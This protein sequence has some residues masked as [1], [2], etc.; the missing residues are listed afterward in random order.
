MKNGGGRRKHVRSREVRVTWGRQNASCV[1]R[2]GKDERG[3]GDTARS[4]HA[5][6]L[7]FYLEY[8]GKVPNDFMWGDC[9]IRFIWP[10]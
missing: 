10:F 9:I 8:D 3:W 7:G 2:S 5:K 1:S 4:W 6:G